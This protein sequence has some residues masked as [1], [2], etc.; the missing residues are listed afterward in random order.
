MYAYTHML[1]HTHIH[2]CTRR[3]A[4]MSRVSRAGRSGNLNLAGSN[5][6]P[7]GLNPGRVK[8]MALKLI[9]VAF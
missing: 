4:Q 5:L 7:A 3:G 8:P 6:D 1:I 9:L 2:A